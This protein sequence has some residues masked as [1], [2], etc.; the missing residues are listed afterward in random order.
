MTPPARHVSPLA[1]SAGRRLVVALAACGGLWTAIAWA[2][3]W[4]G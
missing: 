3:D 4:I 2:L 1:A